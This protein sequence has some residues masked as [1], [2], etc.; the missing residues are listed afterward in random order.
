MIPPE[1]L[2]FAI[3]CAIWLRQLEEEDGGQSVGH[4]GVGQGAERRRAGISRWRK[5]LYDKWLRVT[6]GV[7]RSPNVGKADETREK[8]VICRSF[9]LI[10]CQIVDI[11][12][13][14]WSV[15]AQIDHMSILKAIS[16]Y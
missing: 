15:E 16:P 1:P 6:S 9:R 2:A 3:S 13:T 10:L 7:S 8:R 5:S 12:P 14:R 4:P 11:W